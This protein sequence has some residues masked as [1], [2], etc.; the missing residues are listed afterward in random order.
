L[1][2][3]LKKNPMLIQ[4]KLGN[5]ESSAVGDRVIDWLPLEWYESNK[6]IQRRKTLSGK[7]V[8]LKFLNDNPRL[9]QG[10]I[11]FA[12]DL[13]VI[14]VDI[15]PC[16]AIVIRPSAMYEMAAVCYEIG[17]KHLPVFY[18][19]D[20]IVTPLELPLLRLLQTGG[21][22]VR[23]E[24]RKLLHPLKTSVSPHPHGNGGSSLFSKILQITNPAQ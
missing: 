8:A 10:D 11:L 7:E 6:R 18:E 15:I 2:R 21:Y 17:N 1:D 19:A 22:D 23:Q 12:D 3:L 24:T 13:S 14:A 5:I 20:E 9:T 4:T 16:D